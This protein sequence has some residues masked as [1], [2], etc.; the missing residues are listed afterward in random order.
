MKVTVVTLRWTIL[1]ALCWLRAMAAETTAFVDV[2]V[3]PMDAERVLEH[4]TVLVTGDRITMIGAA[5]KSRC[6]RTR[7]ESTVA[8]AS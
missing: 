7:A 1:A 5:A 8:A 2:S 4:R 6:L 3:L